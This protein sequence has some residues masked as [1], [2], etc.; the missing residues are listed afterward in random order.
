M[1]ADSFFERRRL[2]SGDREIEEIEAAVPQVIPLNS[3]V[4]FETA[5]S[6][7][8]DDTL[9][10]SLPSDMKEHKSFAAIVQD[11]ERVVPLI[12]AHLRRRPSFLFL[13]LEEITGADPVPETAYGNL[14]A[15]VDAWLQWLRT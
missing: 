4:A 11:G 12:A 8:F 9:F 15:T 1:L 13:A 10:D 2:G 3:R 7:W 6:Q 14:K 5:V